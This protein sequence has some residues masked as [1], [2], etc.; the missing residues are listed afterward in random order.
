VENEI[1]YIMNNGTELQK[2]ALGQLHEIVLL[3]GKLQMS[4]QVRQDLFDGY[5]SSSDSIQHQLASSQ[6][7]QTHLAFENSDKPARLSAQLHSA[8]MEN[9]EL[10]KQKTTLAN[11]ERLAQKKLKDTT[12]K[13]TKQTTLLASVQAQNHRLQDALKAVT[14]T[15]VQ[16]PPNHYNT[17]ATPF[18]DVHEASL[19]LFGGHPPGYFP[20]TTSSSAMPNME[21]RPSSTPDMSAPRF[22][23]RGGEMTSFGS[24]FG[25]YNSH[26]HINMGASAGIQGP[27]TP[28]PTRS[29]ITGP[30]PITTQALTSDFESL[31]LRSQPQPV[32]SHRVYQ[33]CG[34][35]DCAGGGHCNQHQDA[36]VDREGDLHLVGDSDVVD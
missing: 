27:P 4:D 31:R 20:K 8:R 28:L 10:I 11:S 34:R 5:R 7:N 21:T 23:F 30:S 6:S 22:D 36:D 19:L 1:S 2:H 32:E 33:D 9:E 26:S 15:W 16:Y 18:N 25:T 24:F 12:D 14:G 13:H 3:Q 29:P 17:S 35:G